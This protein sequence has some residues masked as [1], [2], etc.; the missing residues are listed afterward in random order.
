MGLH[1]A[2]LGVAV[3]PV[4]RHG[5]GGQLWSWG[6]RGLHLGGGWQLWSGVG[7]QCTPGAALAGEGGVN[8]FLSPFSPAP[9]MHGK[10]LKKYQY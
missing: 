10:I 6:F 5:C 4:S 7:V 8:P 3:S 2:V 1:V 9:N